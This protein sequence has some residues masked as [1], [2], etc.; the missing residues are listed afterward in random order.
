MDLSVDGA[1]RRRIIQKGRATVANSDAPYEFFVWEDGRVVF[2]VGNGSTFQRVFSTFKLSIN[3]WTHV[4]AT[5]DGS[6]LTLYINGMVDASIAQTISPNNNINALA[7]GVANLNA[8]NDGNWSGRLDEIRVWDDARTAGEIQGNFSKALTGNESNLVA[9][10]RF[11]QGIA[12]GDNT[13]PAINVLPDRSQNQNDGTL[14][15][16]TLN[17]NASNWVDSEAFIPF[18]PTNLLVTEVSAS[19]IDLTWTDSAFNE[20]GF[21]IER[22]TDYGFTQNLVTFNAGSNA[23]AT[24]TF[25]NT[26]T[27]SAETAYFYRVK[28][29]NTSGESGYSNIKAGT[30]I[31]PPGHALDFDGIDDFVNLGSLNDAF[32]GSEGSLTIEFWF[33]SPTVVGENA[34]LLAINGSGGTNDNQ[35]ILSIRTDDQIALNDNSNASIQE[36]IGPIVADNSW[37]HLAYTRDGSSGILYLDGINIGTHT[38]DFPINAGDL[39]SLGQ[40]YDGISSPGNYYGGI[41]D[42]V[43]IWSSVRSQSEIQDN[44]FYVLTGSEPN[45]EA[46]YRFDQGIANG[47]NTTP[48]INVLPDRSQNQNDGTLN[49]FALTGTTS[50]WVD[51]EALNSF[52]PFLVTNLN[53][54]GTGSLSWCIGNANSTVGPNTITFDPPIAGGTILAGTPFNLNDDG[55][56]I[57]GDID[58]DL[59]PDISIDGGLSGNNG[60]EIFSRDNVLLHLNLVGFRGPLGSPVT[61]I[62]IDGALAVNNKIAGCYLGT[63]LIGGDGGSLLANDHGISIVNGASENI[64]G[65]ATQGY[66]TIAG[67]ENGGHGIFIDGSDN[68]EIYANYIGLKESGTNFLINDGAGIYLLNCDGTTI[69]HLSDRNYISTNRLGGIVIDN[70]PNTTVVNNYIGLDVTGVFAFG[71]TGSGVEIINVSDGTRIGTGIAGAGN[72]I[73]ANTYGIRSSSNVSILGNTIGLNGAGDTAMPNSIGVEISPGAINVTIGDGTIDGRNIISGN[74][75][76]GIYINQGSST[77]LGNYIGLHSDGDQVIGNGVGISMFIADGSIIGGVGAGQENVISGNTTGIIF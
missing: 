33:N 43:R 4:A 30:T 27:L 10:Y 57:N 39:W 46:Y 50:N 6:N 28:A 60:I 3:R 23:G 66:N 29:T 20:D 71:N 74:S 61:A 38:A 55:T 26:S 25:S 51:S 69:G 2:G 7:I 14:N 75:S 65:D 53:S 12:N 37:H 63:N 52:D 13:T 21:T 8:P 5:W 42:E 22:A 68:N 72:V 40:E 34:S 76:I 32:A 9:Y 48:A 58:G 44:R 70:S 15:G 73:S 11:D 49:G 17:G 18:A 1:S 56:T 62:Q 41:M 24:G 47:D 31:A 77:V 64:I 45:L 59:L 19:Q 16:F 67:S 54:T 36:I 35:L